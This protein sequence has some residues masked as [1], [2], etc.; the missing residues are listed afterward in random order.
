MIFDILVYEPTPYLHKFAC[1][2][3]KLVNL[4]FKSKL[5]ENMSNTKNFDFAIINPN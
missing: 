1:N 4:I 3:M 5:N 2:F